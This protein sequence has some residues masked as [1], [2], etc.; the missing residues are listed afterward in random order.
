M[1]AELMSWKERFKESWSKTWNQFRRFRKSHPIQLVVM[2]IG[3]GILFSQVS[4]VWNAKQ[5]QT[6]A[7]E[8]VH[9]LPSITL[10]DLNA[11]ASEGHVRK[12][13]SHEIKDGSWMYPQIKNY[14]EIVDDKN[15]SFAFEQTSSN[16]L[17]EEFGK[18]LFTNSLNNPVDFSTGN[19]IVPS[20]VAGLMTTVLFL[21]AILLLIT[22]GQKLTAEVLGGHSFKATKPDLETTLEHVIGYESVKRQLRELKDQLSNP[23]LY[24]KRGVKP[25]KGILFTGD[26]GVGKTMMAKA[27]AN[28]LGADFFTCTGADFVEMYVGVGAKRARTLFKLA[29]MSA[30]SVIFIDE[31]DA[32]GSRDHM[33]NDTERLST[34]NAILAEM[35]GI[36]GNHRMVVIGATNHPQRLDNAL[37]RPGRFDHIVNI[38][39]PDHSTREGIL[40]HYLKNVD[41]DPAID[42]KALALRTN[43]Y[44]GA[45]LKNM[46]EEATRLAARQSGV[47]SDWIV[48]ES[49]LH[50]AQ[51]KNLLGLNERNSDGEDLVRVAVHELGHALVGY[52]LCPE[53][54]IEKV[55]V[56]GLGNS[57]G[58][59][60]TR[61]LE[62]KQLHTKRQMTGRLAMM[63]AGR[64]SEEVVLG[65]VTGGAAD[66]IYRAN[67]LARVMV[68]D[69]GMGERSGFVRQNVGLDGKSELT[70]E[71]KKDI[72]A[73]LV[74][75]YTE[76]KQLVASH[77]RWI[78]DNT[79]RLM[80]KGV[81][82]HSELFDGFDTPQEDRSH[83]WIAQLVKQREQ[84]SEELL[85]LD[86]D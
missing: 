37:K 24:N 29:R 20:S 82:V 45:Q 71:A 60:F 49:L 36:N 35:D 65:D 2:V 75:A 10:Q 8:Y 11:K 30:V 18:M 16:L 44:S 64:A 78:A 27:F 32:L 77:D 85:N 4:I 74:T 38:P 19:V 47:D 3:L 43:G 5:Q 79:E 86:K 14:L 81:L 68:C 76:A 69:Y 6:Q 63:L 31:I 34:L 9:A 61:P 40:R 84:R 26:P 23:S 52:V 42:L 56:E 59:A 83:K 13:I 1:Q 46:V 58:Y 7:R 51:E 67:E 72:E 50:L 25:P 55:T 33:G 66:D 22:Y 53:M 62:D 41:S 15:K 17:N 57:L 80:Q 21:F 54:H 39:L 12:V 28:E 48:T 70:E 73:L